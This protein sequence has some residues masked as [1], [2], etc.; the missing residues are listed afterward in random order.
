MDELQDSLDASW[1]DEEELMEQHQQGGAGT[2]AGGADMSSLALSL[3]SQAE[4]NNELL[5]YIQHLEAQ[6]SQA[7]SSLV[8]QQSRVEESDRHAAS[9]R[10]RGEELQRKLLTATSLFEELS[11]RHNQHSSEAGL[12][13][14]DNAALRGQV[15]ELS[16]QKQQL[17]ADKHSSAERVARLEAELSDLKRRR[18]ISDDDCTDSLATLSITL[19]RTSAELDAERGR[20]YEAQ[21]GMSLLKDEN[22][23]MTRR[24][25]H[26]VRG[27]QE[28][29]EE[30]EGRA[31]RSKEAAVTISALQLQVP[32]YDTA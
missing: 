15:S 13:S 9:S 29:E 16:Q 3:S 21:L 5:Q 30:R 7:Q 22:I 24:L 10:E 1:H 14:A 20:V 6:F 28:Q 27:E 23:Q 17:Q 11:E 2:A 25:E 8:Q 31:R 12:V 26:L 32:T 18:L 4:Y 19:E